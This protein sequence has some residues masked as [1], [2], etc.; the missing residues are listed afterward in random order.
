MQKIGLKYYEDF[1]QRIPRTEVEELLERVKQ[2][3]WK[4]V[5]NADKCLQVEACG[6]YRREK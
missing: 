4:E 6:S 3:A 5:K 1:K 2:A